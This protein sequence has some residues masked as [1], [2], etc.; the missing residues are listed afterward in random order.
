MIRRPPRSTL[1]PYTTLFRSAHGEDGLIGLCLL[2]FGVMIKKRRL[3]LES[4]KDHLADRYGKILV[5]VVELWQVNHVER[6]GKVGVFAIDK[7]ALRGRYH[8]TNYYR[9][10]HV[11]ARVRALYR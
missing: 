3:A 6:G 11:G 10:P 9:Q 2:S 4:G 1:F 5:H 8:S 7:F